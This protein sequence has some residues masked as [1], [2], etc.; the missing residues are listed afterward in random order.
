MGEREKENDRPPAKGN[1]LN[2]E[3]GR[4]QRERKR[5]RTNKRER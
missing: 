1:V 5:K 3:E 2:V 4:V